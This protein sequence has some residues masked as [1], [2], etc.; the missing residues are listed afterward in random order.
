M[1]DELERLR[2]SKGLVQLLTHYTALGETDR[3]QWQDRVMAMDPADAGKL[4]KWHGE[5]LA[6]GWIEQNTGLTPV[7][8]PGCAAACY[9]VTSA[10]RRALRDAENPWD[11]DEEVAT[12]SSAM[13]PAA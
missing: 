13:D 12:G 2:K 7:L 9:R 8:K 10:G 5:L 4:V 1:F 11:L 6:F 3:K